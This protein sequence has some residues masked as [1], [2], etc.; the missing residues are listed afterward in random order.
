M[1][2]QYNNIAQIVE[3]GPHTRDEPNH[4]YSQ[5]A[6]SVPSFVPR[7][8]LRS[9]WQNLVLLWVLVQL[10]FLQDGPLAVDLV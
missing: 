5:G 6:F 2:Y 9:M 3:A 7:K 8:L 1:V 4:I 10:L